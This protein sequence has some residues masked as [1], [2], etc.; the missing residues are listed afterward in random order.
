MLA[1]HMLWLPCEA[2]DYVTARVHVCA[3]YTF[4]PLDSLA[5]SEPFVNTNSPE[6]SVRVPQLRHDLLFGTWIPCYPLFSVCL[7][8]LKDGRDLVP[9]TVYSSFL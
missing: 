8:C 1:A 4:C 2:D 9:R 6:R 7:T 3:L 5:S